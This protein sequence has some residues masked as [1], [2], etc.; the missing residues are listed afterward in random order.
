MQLYLKYLIFMEKLQ[1]IKHVVEE[2]AL[3]DARRKHE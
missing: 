2:K 3:C 1:Q